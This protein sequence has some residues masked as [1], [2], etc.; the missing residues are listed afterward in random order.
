MLTRRC[1]QVYSRR[2]RWLLALQAVRR[3]AALGG[4]GDPDAH[5][6]AAHFCLAARARATGAAA[7][8]RP[9]HTL[10]RSSTGWFRCRRAGTALHA[11]YRI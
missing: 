11:L 2:G 8:A 3:A 10:V 1:A 5:R 7:Q 9:L 6:L 4:T